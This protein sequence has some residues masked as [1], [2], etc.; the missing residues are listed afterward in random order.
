[1]LALKAINFCDFKLIYNRT[2]AFYTILELDKYGATKPRLSR[3]VRENPSDLEKIRSA[4]KSRK[5]N[6]P[7]SRE[8]Y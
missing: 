5:K 2:K 8:D 4:K 6:A 3:N 1:M 7:F